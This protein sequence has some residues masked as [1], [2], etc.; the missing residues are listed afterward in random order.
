MAHFAYE[1]FN[2]GL[3]GPIVAGSA[4]AQVQSQADTGSPPGVESPIVYVIDDELTIQR[5]ISRL[6]RSAGFSPRAFSTVDAFLAGEPA[7]HACVI[8]DVSLEGSSS[9][10]LPR[11]LRESGTDL[12]VIFVTAWDTQEMRAKARNA[13]G[14]AYFRKPID[15]QALI[16]SINW[17]LSLRRSRESSRSPGSKDSVHP[18]SDASG[19]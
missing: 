14:V 19:H 6:M 5:A 7:E 11:R 9:L 16:D 15:D 3:D 1:Y 10:E 17:A 4:V 8:A 13:G 18:D 12:P 2:W